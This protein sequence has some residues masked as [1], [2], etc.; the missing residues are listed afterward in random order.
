MVGI[1]RKLQVHQKTLEYH[2]RAHVQKRKLI[3]SYYV[4]WMGGSKPGG[5][6]QVLL[7]C[8]IFK[9]LG[10]DLQRLQRAVS[11]IPFLRSEY[12][13]EA[14]TYVALLL[15]PVKEAVTVLNYI[16]E[17]VPELHDR[18]QVGYIKMDQ[19]FQFEVPAHLYR[20]GWT[21]DLKAAKARVSRLTKRSGR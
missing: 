21:F 8:L 6:S 13:T 10:D 2:Y 16:N 1:A 11:R 9:D 15:T 7:T 5:P 18:V 17:E 14:G 20:K 4:S 3:S 19:S 12:L